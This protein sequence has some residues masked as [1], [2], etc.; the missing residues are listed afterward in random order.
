MV[1]VLPLCKGR[2]LNKFDMM[3]PVSIIRDMD[4]QQLDVIGDGMSKGAEG[5]AWGIARAKASRRR[6]KM[7]AREAGQIEKQGWVVQGARLKAKTG[8]GGGGGGVR[9][10]RDGE[11]GDDVATRERG[12]L[13]G[14]GF[15]DLRDTG[16]KVLAWKGAKAVYGV[17]CDS[18]KWMKCDSRRGVSFIDVKLKVAEICQTRHTLFSNGILGKS[19]W[20]GFCKRTKAS[21]QSFKKLRSIKRKQVQTR[22]SQNITW[23]PSKL[24]A[25]HNYPPSNI[26]NADETGF[27][28]LR[29]K[30]MKVLAWKGSKAVY[31]VTCDSREWMTILCCVN[32]AGYAIPSYYIFKGSRIVSNYIENCEQGVAMAVQ[33]KAWMT[34]E[35]FQ[36]WL[37]HFENSIMIDISKESRHLLILDGHGSHVSLEV[38]AKAHAL[39]IDIITL[40]AHTSHKLQPLDVSVFK[41]LKVQS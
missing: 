30:G 29:D 28:D 36:A 35:L 2:R 39:G 23:K 10:N 16:M 27:Q 14:T 19:W 33:K 22:D 21:F 4:I 24:Y 1:V 6:A 26:W 32:A 34:K 38:V 25:E 17:T 31:D 40:P 13:D 11:E 9:A 15:Q 12:W 7:T 37:Q 3:L 41:S 5:R 8:G 20:E 18:R